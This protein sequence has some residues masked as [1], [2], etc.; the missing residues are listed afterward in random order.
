MGVPYSRGHYLA[1]RDMLAS[2]V[3]PAYRTIWHRDPTGRW[4]IFTNSDP[5]LSCPRYFGSVTAVER[6]PAIELTWRDDRTLDVS[7]S[8]RLSWRLIL[9]A[10]PATQMMTTMGSATPQWAWNSDAVLASMG[11]MASGFLRS[12]RIKLRG[13]TPNGPRFK[14]APMQV[15][16]VAGGQ[17]VVDDADL[18]TLAPLTEQA[19]L[20]DFWLPQR[21]L[22]FAGQA[23]FTKPVC[24]VEEKSAMKSRSTTDLSNIQQLHTSPPQ[25]AL[26]LEGNCHD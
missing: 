20:G 19:R 11:S 4:T 12:G 8:D 23:R 26:T 18:G 25:S 7:M 1:L 21:G 10:T 17:A 22:F 24:D 5:D 3:G 13:R 2:S 16:R 15:W 6:V 14:A 9:E